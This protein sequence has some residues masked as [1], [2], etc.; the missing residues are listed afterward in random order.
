VFSNWFVLVAPVLLLVAWLVSRGTAWTTDARAMEA[1][2]LFDACVTLPALYALCYARSLPLPQL[3]LRMLGVAC[4]NVYLLGYIVPAEAQELLP[5][6]A[7]ARWI[8]LGLLILIELKIMFV[9][10]RLVFGANATAEEVAAKTGAPPL[11]AKLMVMEARMW[12]A[13]GRFLRGR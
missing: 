11:I 1:A 5:Q 13:V 3:A 8:G 7:V 12:K 9:A 6:F 4:L 10:V 2:L